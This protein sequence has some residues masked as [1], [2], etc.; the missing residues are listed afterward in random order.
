MTQTQLLHSTGTVSTYIF[1]YRIFEK[2][3]ITCV[4]YFEIIIKLIIR[5]FSTMEFE[6]LTLKFQNLRLETV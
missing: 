6:L 1:F 4:N 2:R 5:M 3:F